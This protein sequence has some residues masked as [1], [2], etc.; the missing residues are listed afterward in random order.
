MSE[1][2]AARIFVSYDM[3]SRAIA[4]QVVDRLQRAGAEVSDVEAF[5]AAGK[6]YSDQMRDA[7]R[8]SDVFVAVMTSS[9]LGAN[10]LILLGAAIG[11]GKPVIALAAGVDNV[12]L[13]VS[14]IHLLPINRADEVIDFAHRAHAA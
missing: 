5:T 11:A 3:A 2:N 6:N 4:R 1:R 8:E 12:D 14:S 9:Q 13:P 7:I 10:S